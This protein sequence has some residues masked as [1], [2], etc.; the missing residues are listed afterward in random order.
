MTLGD[1][2][3]SVETYLKIMQICYENQFE[4]T[5]EVEEGLEEIQ[6]PK[7]ILQPLIGN[8]FKHGFTFEF[9]HNIIRLEAKRVDGRIWI[10]I[11]DNG[12][13]IKR[14][15]LEKLNMELSDSA[16]LKKGRGFG[17]YSINRRIN[18]IYGDKYGVTVES[19][20]KRYTRVILNF[21]A[22]I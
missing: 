9:S 12:I 10:S 17:L 16:L 11:Y 7:M 8:V 13:G 18:T 21:P 22:E 4:M 5:Y 15:V 20:E 2:L 14:E 1:E 19:C 3:K 6:V